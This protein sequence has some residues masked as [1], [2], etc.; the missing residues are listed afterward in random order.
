M[1]IRFGVTDQYLQL[2]KHHGNMFEHGPSTNVPQF[3]FR[4]LTCFACYMHI[5]VD[6]NVKV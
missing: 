5:L 6:I 1:N 3:H 2:P 4:E